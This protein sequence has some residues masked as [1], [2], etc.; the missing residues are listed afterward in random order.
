MELRD[1]E[2]ASLSFDVSHRL[3]YSLVSFHWVIFPASRQPNYPTHVSRWSEEFSSQTFV[4]HVQLL[5]TGLLGV[6]RDSG[7]AST[8][9]LR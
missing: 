5:G 1:V 2:Y 7:R 8:Q 9:V 6:V 4:L 3:L